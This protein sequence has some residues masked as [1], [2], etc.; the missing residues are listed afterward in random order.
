MLNA[1]AG[2]FSQLA[3]VP[4]RGRSSEGTLAVLHPRRAILAT[5]AIFL[6]RCSFWI[7]SPPEKTRTPEK[8]SQ[9]WSRPGPGQSEFSV[10]LGKLN[11]EPTSGLENR[12]PLLITSLLL[13]VLVHPGVSG[14]CAYLGGFR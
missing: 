6:D 11:R 8:T 14:N 3:W 5:A 12:L 9:S 13:Y 7:L 10:G 4:P 1:R 2:S